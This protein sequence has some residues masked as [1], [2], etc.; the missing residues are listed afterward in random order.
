MQIV[1]FADFIIGWDR[2][3]KWNIKLVIYSGLIA[4]DFYDLY[5]LIPYDFLYW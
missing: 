1:D 3:V 2:H 4:C 5:G